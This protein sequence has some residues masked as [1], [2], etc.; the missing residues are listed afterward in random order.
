M[1]YSAPK[2]FAES[3]TCPHCNTVARQEWWSRAWNGE[4]YGVG[5]GSLHV[6][7]CHHCRT[8]SVWV[9]D[10][11]YYPESTTAPAPNTDMPARVLDLYEEAASIADKSPRGAAA[12]LRLAIQVLCKELGESGENINSDI[13]NLVAKGLK[14]TVQQALDVVRVTGNDAVHPGQI[15]TDDPNT[16]QTLFRLVNIIIE[17]MITMPGEVSGLFNDLPPD[18]LKGI[19]DRDKPKT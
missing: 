15:D 9:D 11:M 7:T 8:S 10:V 12:L 2:V 19:A 6:A 13:G 17:Y 3:Y 14:P 16:V 4:N 5:Q 1:A 18:K